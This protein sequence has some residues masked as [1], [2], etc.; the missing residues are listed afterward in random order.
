MEI[1]LSKSVGTLMAIL[2][3]I[4][5]FSDSLQL[6]LFHLVLCG[7]VFITVFVINVWLPVEEE[8]VVSGKSAKTAAP[9]SSSVPRPPRGGAKI[10]V[11]SAGDTNAPVSQ[12]FPAFFLSFW[13]LFFKL[14]LRPL[15]Q[16]FHHI[17]PSN[18]QLFS[19]KFLLQFHALLCLMD[20]LS[21]IHQ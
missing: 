20:F 3:F 13:F 2:Y 18:S 5:Q 15:V 11:Y 17:S 6:L 1:Y 12:G 7:V 19:N 21:L 9:P 10:V 16:P 14:S 8:C 4:L